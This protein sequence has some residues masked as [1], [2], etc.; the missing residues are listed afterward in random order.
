[1]A[2]MLVS[3]TIDANEKSFVNGTP[4]WRR[5]RHVQTKNYK[6]NLKILK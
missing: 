6:S 5:W 2:A 3:L 1:M 4:T